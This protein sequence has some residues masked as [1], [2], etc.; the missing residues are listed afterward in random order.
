MGKRAIII[1]LVLILAGV[2]GY[3]V[4][5]NN[6][7]NTAT[8]AT[9]TGQ[10]VTVSRGNLVATVASSGL[11]ASASQV[12]LSFGTSGTVKQVYVKLGDK[13][14]KGQVLADLDATQLQF[15]QA[16]AQFALNQSQIKYDTVK[17]GPLRWTL[18]LHSLT[19][20]RRRPTTTPPSAR[21]V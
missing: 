9:T 1:V 5:T 8:A 3:Y 20:I 18:R 19:W 10:V 21:P 2:A 14:T 17:A 11:V 15:A 12:S 6:Y 13:V 7:T 4:Y 16:N